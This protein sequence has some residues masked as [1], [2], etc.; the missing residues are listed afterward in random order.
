VKNINNSQIKL[1][2]DYTIA[3]IFFMSNQPEKIAGKKLKAI[4]D[5]L[6]LSRKSVKKA[7]GIPISTLERIE[8]GELPYPISWLNALCDFYVVNKEDIYNNNKPTVDW[9]TL[10]RRIL[11]KH[12]ENQ[13]IV[14][15]LN[16]KPYPKKAIVHRILKTQYLDNYRNADELRLHF[17]TRYG[18]SFTY[19][20]LR[21]SLTSLEE[22][23]ILEKRKI[24]TEKTEFRRKAAS[25]TSLDQT[26]D[27]IRRFLEENTSQETLNLVNPVFDRMARMLY[28]LKSGPNTRA[29]IFTYAGFRN[30]TNNINRSLKVLEN[31]NLVEMTIKDKP[32]SSKQMYRLTE[33]GYE[34][35]RK[36]GVDLSPH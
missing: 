34:L 7:I 13:K 5:T 19:T 16:S 20:T 22:K 32:R 9:K 10:R 18:L 27:E 29:E 36:A 3:L 23:G 35:L 30:E 28:L 31:T 21:N 14:K 4:R 17:K 15:V 8:N 2:I 24:G 33:K 25:S 12:K 6:L 26:I 11:S 1:Q